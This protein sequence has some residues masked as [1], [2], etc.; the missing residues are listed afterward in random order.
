[1]AVDLQD[2]EIEYILAEDAPAKIA[3]NVLVPDT[4]L[5]ESANISVAAK[6]TIGEEEFETNA[7]EVELNVPLKMPE[8]AL[9]FQIADPMDDVEEE[10]NNN[11]NMYMDSSD[12]E[13]AWDGDTEQMI[14]LRFNEINVPAG[15]KVAEAYVLFTVDETKS[16]K[17]VNPFNL[18]IVG[19][20]VANSAAFEAVENNLSDRD[21]TE[22]KVNWADIP[23]WTKEGNSNK[24]QLTPNLASIIQEIIDQDGWAEGNSLSIFM[25]GEGVRCADAYEDDPATA[26][27]LIIVLE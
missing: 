15:A 14:G 2:A 20:K 7:V 4:S 27:K 9:V 24:D 1:M 26:A 22:A 10:L 21:K 18:D 16:S 25:S 13:L 6:V 8:G 5:E 23:E 12:L 17:N 3:Y 11:G 19:E